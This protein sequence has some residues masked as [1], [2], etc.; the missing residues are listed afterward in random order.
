MIMEIEG[1]IQAHFHNRG[2]P[3]PPPN[4]SPPVDPNPKCH[5]SFADTISRYSPHNR[6]T[7]SIRFIL[8]LPSL[9]FPEFCSSKE[10]REPRKGIF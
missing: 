2:S 1:H 9:W 5:P 10:E 6:L 4:N 7:Q 8:S 3:P